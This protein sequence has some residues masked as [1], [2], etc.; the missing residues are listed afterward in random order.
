MIKNVKTEKFYIGSTL[1]LEE[2]WKFHLKELRRGNHNVKMQDAWDQS[3][4]SDWEWT[5]IEDDIPFQLQFIS[6]QYWLDATKCYENGYNVAWKAGSYVSYEYSFLIQKD[7]RLNDILKCIENRVPYRTIAKK[8]DVSV[9][10]VGRCKERFLKDLCKL[11]KKETVK[12]TKK[13]NEYKKEQKIRKELRNEKVKIVKEMLNDGETYRTI[14]KK[15]K[16]SLGFIG[17]IKNE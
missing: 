8:Y 2:R 14:A 17:K 10:Y 15:V 13:V 5:I 11:D 1:D 16:C 9:G 3:E 4:E 6:E 12:R 7:E